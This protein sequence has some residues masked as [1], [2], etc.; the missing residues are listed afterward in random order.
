MIGVGFPFPIN[1]LD[2]K[3]CWKNAKI[4]FFASLILVVHIQFIAYKIAKSCNCIF[5][6]YVSSSNHYLKN[7][8]N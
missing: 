2:F 1:F 4:L 8:F 6:F 7:I 3:A 5:I